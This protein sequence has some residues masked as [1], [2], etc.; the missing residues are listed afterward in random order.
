MSPFSITFQSL[1][2][3]SALVLEMKGIKFAEKQSKKKQTNTRTTIW[4][5]CDFGFLKKDKA[6]Y[7]Q[8]KIC[9]CRKSHKYDVTLF[10]GF[11]TQLRKNSSC[12]ASTPDLFP[13][14]GDLIVM[15][16]LSCIFHHVL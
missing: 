14:F 3:I 9:L 15:A 12:P 1:S 10:H 4:H 16:F 2:V 11:G 8:N 13:E 7:L 5:S 6:R